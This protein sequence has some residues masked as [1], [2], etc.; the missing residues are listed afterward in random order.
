MGFEEISVEVN[1]SNYSGSIDRPEEESDRGI[2]VRPGMRHGPYGDIFDRFAR[3][4]AQNGFHCLRFEAWDDDRHPLGERTL[5]DMHADLD[6]AVDLLRDEGCTDISLVGKSFG[7]GM[8]LTYVPDTVGRVVLWA[9]AIVIEDESNLEEIIDKQFKER[10]H[11]IIDTDDL[12]RIN[13]PVRILVGSEDETISIDEV[14]TITSALPE[15][16]YSVYDGMDHSFTGTVEAD[17]VDE[18]IAFI[19]G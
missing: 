16:T 8:A 3:T 17:V 14:E 18:T 11:P 13:V 6:A 4:A 7:G 5:R 1:G 15:A 10:D 9:P 12:E 2:I 19:E